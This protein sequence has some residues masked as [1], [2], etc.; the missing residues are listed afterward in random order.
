[1]ARSIPTK[2]NVVK[3]FQYRPHAL[4]LAFV[5]IWEGPVDTLISK[6]RYGSLLPSFLEPPAGWIRPSAP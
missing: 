2:R 3:H 1:M 5:S 4:V 6:G